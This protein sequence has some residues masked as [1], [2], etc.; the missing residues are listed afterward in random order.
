MPDSYEWRKPPFE[1]SDQLRLRARESARSSSGSASDNP[2][3]RSS[4]SSRTVNVP[5]GNPTRSRKRSCQIKIGGSV[6]DVEPGRIGH[7]GVPPLEARPAAVKTAKALKGCRGENHSSSWSP[8]QN[9]SPPSSIIRCVQIACTTIQSPRRWPTT[10]PWIPRH[11]DP[12]GAS[13]TTVRLF[14]GAASSSTEASR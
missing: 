2:E 5:S 13:F 1:P 8:G 4:S 12:P 7:V 14:R 6:R 10:S 9:D 3:A 11:L